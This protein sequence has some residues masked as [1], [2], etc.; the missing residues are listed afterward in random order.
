MFDHVWGWPL[1]RGQPA[2]PN[3][4]LLASVRGA[5]ECWRRSSISPNIQY[6]RD[7]F[8]VLR[9][10]CI[11][12]STKTVIAYAAAQNATLLGAAERLIEDM[13]E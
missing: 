3:K 6:R 13:L 11:D 1:R 4:D 12:L 7:D 2:R 5:F 8:E 9:K 10:G